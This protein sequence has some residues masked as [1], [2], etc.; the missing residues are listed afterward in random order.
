MNQRQ[1]EWIGDHNAN[2]QNWKQKASHVSCNMRR[3]RTVTKRNTSETCVWLGH[4]INVDTENCQ[5]YIRTKFRS[6]RKNINQ[7]G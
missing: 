6:E 3:G 5:V 7:G 4:I 2:V 1:T